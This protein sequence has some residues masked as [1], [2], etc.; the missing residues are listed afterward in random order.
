MTMLEIGA[1]ISLLQ[2]LWLVLA[3]VLWIG[4]F[5]LEGF[6][7]GVGML[8]VFLGRTDRERR[9]VKIGSTRLNSSHPP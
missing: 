3:A 7:F 9:L 8:I 2:G 4:F 5:F 6:D 1:Q